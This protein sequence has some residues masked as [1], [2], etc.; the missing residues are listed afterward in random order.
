MNHQHFNLQE[1]SDIDHLSTLPNIDPEPGVDI[2]ILQWPW[3]LTA[4]HPSW[5]PRD[6]PRGF[7]RVY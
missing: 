3:H 2:Y 1:T 7:H 5:K 6:C 4:A